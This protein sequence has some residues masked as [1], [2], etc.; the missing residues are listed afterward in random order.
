MA[1]KRRSAYKAESRTG[2]IGDV[3]TAFSELES[4][5]EEM[6]E[7]FDNMDS[8]NLGATSKCIAYGEAADALENISAA[9]VPEELEDIAVSYVEYVPTRRGRG[10]SRNTRRSNAIA[11][12]QAAVE[13]AR[14]AEENPEIADSEADIDSFVNDLESAISEAEGVEFPGMYG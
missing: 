8:N 14:E 3:A 2:T 12:L 13:A 4:L 9:D 5:A 10:A 6:R 11:I 7:G 1:T